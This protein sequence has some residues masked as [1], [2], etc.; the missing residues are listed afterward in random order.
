MCLGHGPNPNQRTFSNIARLYG[1]AV[2][3]FIVCRSARVSF[4]LGF[5]KSLKM[6]TFKLSRLIFL[7]KIVYSEKNNGG[8]GVKKR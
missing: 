1:T 4:N 3:I 8:G 7:A 6:V 5:L 2:S